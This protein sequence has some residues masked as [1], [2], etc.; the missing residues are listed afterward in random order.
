MKAVL[1]MKITVSVGGRFHAF[2]LAQQLFKRGLLKRLITS[3]PTFEVEKYGIPKDLIKSIIIK[4]IIQRGWQMLPYSIRNVYNPQYL[5]HEIYDKL[6]MNYLLPSDIVVAWSG[7][8]LHTINRAKDMGAITIIERGSSHIL[9][10]NNILRE[11]HEKHG[12]KTPSIHPKIV[13]KELKE[14][15]A[16]GFIAI[17]SHFVKSTFVN[18]NIPEKKLLHVPYGVDLKRFKRTPKEDDI[19]RI[20]HC[21][22][23][24]I[25]KGVH[26]L[27]RAFHELKLPAAEL[28]LIG[29]LEEAMRPLIK[30]Y[31]NA[32]VFLKGQQ[33]QTNLYQ[34]YSQGSVFC[35]CSIEEGLAL[36]QCEAMS[37]GL[38][39]I[40]TTNTGGSD[41]VRDG[42][43]GF[44]IPIM[45]VDAI[46]EK[47]LHLYENQTICRSMGQSALERVQQ[48]FTW[49]DYG[50]KIIEE[51]KRIWK[52]LN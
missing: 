42:I 12:I 2:S 29:N 26:Y 11:E 41:I 5:I 23:I 35:L 8:G 38:P 10:A 14:Y 27:L 32:K 15:A 4:E 17:P 22:S 25:R 31:L 3:Y 40:C 50:K 51:Y 48:G 13:E 45:D 20:I 18:Q 37:C 44:I 6:A 28:W 39:V 30:K 7:F 16:A 33:R 19:F 34:Y 43:D 46:K 36:A 21:G 47:I 9:Y 49:D 52:Q 24:S 1:H